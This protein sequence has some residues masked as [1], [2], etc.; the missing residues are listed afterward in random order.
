M[1]PDVKEFEPAIGV[2]TGPTVDLRAQVYGATVQSYS[3]NLSQAPKAVCVS[4]QNSYR[5]QFGWSFASMSPAESTNTITVTA[6]MT[7]QST[8]T[9]TLTFIV[10]ENTNP[11]GGSG[12]S[13]AWSSVL[14][15]DKVLETQA[16]IVGDSPTRPYGVSA[17]SGTL[18]VGHLLPAYNPGVPALGLSYSSNAAERRPIFIDRYQIPTSGGIPDTVSA[19]LQFNGSWGSS[20]YYQTGTGALYN[21]GAVLQIALQADAG[22]LATGRYDYSVE[23]TAHYSGSDPA[24]TVSGSVTIVNEESSVFGEGWTLDLVDRLHVV[25]GGV[26][27]N[28]GAGNSLWFAGSGPYTTPAGDFSTLVKN[29]DN[30]YTRTLKNGTKQ[31]FGTTGL[32]TSIVDL[33]SNRL[34][35]TYDGSNNL[36]TITDPNSNVTTLSYS[37]SCG[38]SGKVCTITDP[39]N[40]VTSFTYNG[41]GRLE[42]ITDPDGAGHTFTYDSSS[43]R[44]NTL[45]DPLS[46]TTTFTYNFAGRMTMVTRPDS[47]TETFKALQLQSLCDSGECTSGQPGA[48]LL[49]AEAVS[50]YTDPRGN[51]WDTRLD[52][53]GFGTT[54]QL[55]D[56]LGQT[57]PAGHMSVYHR[58]ANG[59]LTAV[60]DR[61]SRNEALALDAKANPT[62]ITHPDLTT[63]L[64][65]F[66]SNSQP[67][68]QTDELGRV[69]TWTY[70][71]AGNL[72]QIK[73]PDPDGGGPLTSP[74]TTLVYDSQGRI[75]SVTDA[76]SNIT[77]LSYD[78]RDRVTEITNADST[79]VTF[80]YDSASNVETRKDERGNTTSFT[81]DG[82]NRPRTVTTPDRDGAGGLPAPVTTFT[83]DSAGNQTQITRPDPDGTGSLTP[84]IST[85]TY[86]SMNRAVTAV[87]ALSNTTTFSYDNAGNLVTVT[88]PLSRTT[89]LTYNE[90]GYGTSTKTPLGNITTFSYDAEGQVTSVQDPIGRTTYTYS[91]R[92]FVATT[93][94]PLSQTTT[95]GYD[96]SGNRTTTTDPMSF[97]VGYQYDNLDRP[98]QYTDQL[99]NKTTFTYDANGN[100][101]SVKD[102]LSHVTTFVYDSRNRQ[103]AVTDALSNTTSYTFDAAGNLTVV[104]D[105][106]SRSTT[107]AYDAANR[108]ISLTQPD[109]DGG[110]SLTSPVTTFVYDNLDRMTSLTD[111]VSNV[112]SWT[113]SAI[114]QV[115]TEIDPLSK[116]VTYTYDAAGQMTRL[117][118]RKNQRRD[119]AYDND[120][121]RTQEYWCPSGS[122]S[123]SGCGTSTPTR[124]FTY[125]YDGANQLTEVNETD[126]RYTF[127]YDTAGRVTGVSSLGSNM[128][129]VRLTNTYNAAG[130]RTAVSD[131]LSTA[132]TVSF[133]YDN[134]QRVTN[135]KLTVGGTVGPTVD[136]G[137]D[138]ANRLTSISRKANGTTF[139]KTTTT[140][141]Y[142]NADRMTAI[143]HTYIPM[144]GSSTTLATYT[145]AYN[146]ASELTVETNKDGTLTYTYDNTSQLTGV[147]G[148]GGT[149]GE[150]G[151]DETF[152][153][154]TNGNRTMTGYTTGSGNRLTSDGTYNYTLDGNGN[155]LTKTRI[156]DSQK[157]EFTWDFRNRLTQV[158]VKDSSNNIL[159]QSDYTYDAFDRRIIKSFDDDGPGPHTA[160]V[161][162]TLYDGAHFAANPYADFNGSNTLTMRYLYAPAVDVILAR[163][164]ASGTVAWYLADHLG[165]V[166]DIANTSGTVLDHISYSAYGKVTAE[167]NASNGDRFKYTGREYDS[168]LSLY[169]YRARYFDATTGR[170]ISADPIA[171][172]AGDSNLYAYVANAPTGGSD[173]LGLESPTSYGYDPN[174]PPVWN[175]PPEPLYT[176]PW[177]LNGSVM[178]PDP[179]V[180]PPVVPPVPGPF[181]PPVGPPV[182]PPK[183]PKGVMKEALAGK[184]GAGPAGNGPLMAGSIPVAIAPNKGTTQTQM[185]GPATGIG[186]GIMMVGMVAQPPS[187]N[188]PKGLLSG[189]P[190]VKMIANAPLLNKAIFAS[191]TGLLFGAVCFVSA[192]LVGPPGPLPFIVM[193]TCVKQSGQVAFYTLSASY[194]PNVV[195]YMKW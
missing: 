90:L 72:T 165:T 73:L 34:T 1:F 178:P 112:T 33:N 84:P 169:Y 54:T 49:A 192:G 142:D 186:Y 46:N 9:Q 179:P 147:D 184:I 15:P 134:A 137:Y 24:T 80:T 39:A 61:L 128:P 17:E 167:T 163:R 156:S 173:P 176:P 122:G 145:Y 2:Q 65:D 88:D 23:T 50:D 12:S 117:V 75:T 16:A 114:D 87:D 28:Q 141:T 74:I 125:S 194:V 3:W 4:G 131:N 159:Q 69:T 40:R 60:T 43:G 105:P 41:S 8:M 45:V 188:G 123:A 44:M 99:L 190:I 135:V 79:R 168:E 174:T 103:T 116:T 25:T 68:K 183:G 106:L 148:S 193:F 76:R 22:S 26:I 177:P 19:R 111:P 64:F 185:F 152:S 151:C 133:T 144:M 82:M 63:R 55:T 119:F 110:G 58:D 157:T 102:A 180:P 130:S 53:W 129:Q 93:V 18:F 121:R 108:R 92:G 20:K 57:T 29:G 21:P 172:A 32:Q 175:P 31:N 138:A 191:V 59:S 42:K 14:A 154:D 136:L 94:N 70:D 91:N 143:T 27:L 195:V 166:R 139:D 158:V 6:T 115:L 98:T 171:F 161:T 113:Y 126:S 160:I 85:F 120:G 96:A 78:T 150:T 89:T 77:S 10:R 7:D 36:S 181:V 35:F 81:Y 182:A 30:T 71:S 107:L 187:G 189:L 95:F 104:T 11:C 56:P 109:P 66:N 124:I 48:A 100:R 86:N 162:K 13:T 5:L 127:T 164:D 97:M 38:A 170:F 47:T 155:T 101:T 146:A 37:G 118:D 67:T 51:A 140:F 153:Y 62:K 149:C 52:W 132:G 83:Y